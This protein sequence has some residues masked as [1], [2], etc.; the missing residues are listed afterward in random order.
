MLIVIAIWY[1]VCEQDNTTFYVYP[2]KIE[3]WDAVKRS[4][5]EVTRFI[6]G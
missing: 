5:L 2:P 4:G 1:G 3:V 6:P